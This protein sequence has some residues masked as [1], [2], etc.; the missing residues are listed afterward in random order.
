MLSLPSRLSLLT[1]EFEYELERS[2]EFEIEFGTR[3]AEKGW[4]DLKATI[5]G[6]L[7]DSWDFLT[8]TPTLVTPTN[9]RL[10]GALAT[11]TRDGATFQRW[12]HKPTLKGDARI[13]F[14]VDGQ[15]VILEEVH[16]NH[17]N[18]TK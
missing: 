9:Y 8:R 3:S 16:T 10:K 14:Y 4:A 18:A 5:R 12:Q 7:A 17:P 1:N 15:K 13:W 11:V 2:T 6:A